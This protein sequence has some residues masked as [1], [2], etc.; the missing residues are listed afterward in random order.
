MRKLPHPERRSVERCAKTGTTAK[1]WHHFS[2]PVFS[3]KRKESKDWGADISASVDQ[4]F[5]K[6]A[7]K[8]F[9]CFLSP[10]SIFLGL[11]K[12]FF[13]HTQ[14]TKIFFLRPKK[15]D[16]GKRKHEKSFGAT[17][18]KSWSTDAEISVPWSSDSFL[19]MEKTG[20]E[21]WCQFLAVV[22]VFVHCS[23]SC[24]LLFFKS[25]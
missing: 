17:F 5:L 9:S 7:P 24:D 23:N 22:L 8:I 25:F 10:E 18:K 19:F 13:A 21:K 16:S 4:L 6:G 3:I 15:I 14:N 12:I 1:N 2:Q 20:H 11:K